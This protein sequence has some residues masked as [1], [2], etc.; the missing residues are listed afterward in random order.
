MPI[1]IE[2][3]AALRRGRSVGQRE[4]DPSNGVSARAIK[5]KNIAGG[6]IAPP[7]ELDAAYLPAGQLSS[8]ALTDGDILVAVT[9]KNP[10]VAVVA[11][12]HSGC[13]ANQGLAVVTP[14]DSDAAQRLLDYLTSDKGQEDL[15]GL[16]TGV[17][18]PSIS[19]ADLRT[20]AVP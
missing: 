14:K 6:F 8:H 19:V 4:A 12:Q 3:L 1:L 5:I 18:I 13:V 9:G 15:R 20:L 17:T 11:A 16:Q 10:K 7:Q 2:D